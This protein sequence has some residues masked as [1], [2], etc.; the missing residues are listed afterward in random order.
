MLSLNSWKISHTYLLQCYWEWDFELKIISL[1]RNICLDFPT[2]I[3]AFSLVLPI[4]QV[5]IQYFTHLMNYYDTEM[6]QIIN[7]D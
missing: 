1:L 2:P 4:L 5:S 7:S 3:P 6:V